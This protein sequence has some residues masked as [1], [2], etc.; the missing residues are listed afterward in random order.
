MTIASIIIQGIGFVAV[1]AITLVSI[2]ISI[3]R[4]GWKGLENDSVGKA[5]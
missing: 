4:F 2:L 3:F 1:E 5:Q